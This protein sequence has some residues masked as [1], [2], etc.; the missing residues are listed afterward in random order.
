MTDPRHD[1]GFV[2]KPGV[3]PTP[4]PA[5]TVVL[6]RDT[7]EGIQTWM[8][9]RVAAMAFAP[10]AAVFPGG[11]VDARDADITVPWDGTTPEQFA[12]RFGTDAP[13]AR[14][15]VTAALRELFEE[16][17][18][19]F[20]HPVPR[21]DLEAARVAIEARELP[22]A[23]FLAEHGCVLEAGRLH[24]W[25]RW[26][27]PP[28]E[29]RRYD[30]WFFVA[31]LP[32]EV[33]VRAVSSEADRAGWVRARAMLDANARGENRLLPPTIAMLQGLV[34]AGTVAAVIAEAPGRSL[35]PVH[36]EVTRGADGRNIVT[37]AGQVFGGQTS[38]TGATPTESAPTESAP[39]G[40]APTTG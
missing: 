28:M 3:I 1:D 19:L 12:T 26:V 4:V 21:A 11:S 7:D 33:E 34:D 40:A 17:S 30:T 8:M 18:V 31:A 15:L 25:A 16:T 35:D 36:P 6:I 27:T 37:A 10:G 2:Q 23:A 24:P 20:A 22:L 13:T 5:S 9:R 32:P 39:G 14:E 38:P 29:S